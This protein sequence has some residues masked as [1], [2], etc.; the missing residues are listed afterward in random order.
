MILLDTPASVL[1]TDIWKLIGEELFACELVLGLHQTPAA[2]C[3]S[4]LQ[5][6][7][8]VLRTGTSA[9][10]TAPAR[11]DRARIRVSATTVTSC[12][13]T[14]AA[15]RVSLR[16]SGPNGTAFQIRLFTAVYP[17]SNPRLRRGKEGMLPEPGRHCV[18]RQRAG[19]Q[20]HQAGMLL[21]HWSGLGRSL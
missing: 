8:N 11:T 4:A 7:T 19:H 1:L 3:V 15:V 2:A 17:C 9:S 13:R 12:R 14:N 18:L 20:R 10:R 21:L 16:R 5:M 6:W